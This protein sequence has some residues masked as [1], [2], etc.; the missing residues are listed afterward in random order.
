MWPVP[1]V[2]AAPDAEAGGSLR[3]ALATQ[4]KPFLKSETKPGMMAHVF[5]PST[6]R[7]TDL[8]RE[9]QNNVNKGG[10]CPS[11]VLSLAAA[12]PASA[13]KSFLRYTPHHHKATMSGNTEPSIYL[14]F[15]KP[16]SIF[17]PNVI[18]VH[19]VF[20]PMGMAYL[21]GPMWWIFL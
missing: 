7:Q 3:P 9:F 19:G 2:P 13:T 11:P 15:N 16:H 17:L 10:C 8:Q 5:S 1:G 21:L 18:A 6:W 20:L 4:Q 12:E 14:L